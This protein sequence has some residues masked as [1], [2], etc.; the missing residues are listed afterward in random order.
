MKRRSRVGAGVSFLPASVA[1]I[2]SAIVAASASCSSSSTAQG[3]EGQH[4]FRNGTCDVGLLCLSDLC[5]RPPDGGLGGGGRGGNG[6]NGGTGG[7]TGG[8]STAGSTGAGGT[9][10]RGGAGGVAGT[11]AG[12]TGGVISIGGSGGS[13]ATGTCGDGVITSGEVC[14]DGNTAGGDGCAAD[15]RSATAGYVCPVPGRPCFPRCG[16]G[17]KIGGEGCDDGNA[18]S[19]DG[20]SAVCQVEPGASCTGAAGG[21]STCTAS[22][23]G[24]G[25]KEGNEGCDC[26]SDPANLPTGCKGPNGLFFGDASGCSKACTKEPTCR[27]SSGKNQACSVSCGNG[28]VEMGEACDDGNNDAGDG[29]SPTCTVET[30]FA[31]SNVMQDDSVPCADAANGGSTAKCLQQPIIYRDFKNESAS[32]GHPDFFYLGALV[33]N[34][35]TVAGVD[36]QGGSTSFS[37]RYCVPN[38]SGPAKKNDA[39]NRCWDLAQ[40][41]L[42]ST[43]KPVFN[44]ARTGA[45]SNPLFCD[46]QFIDWSTDGSAG[47]LPGYT[48]AA[49]GPTNGLTFTDGGTGHP[50]YR[51]PAPVVTSA[52][53]FG[54]W[55]VDS[56]STGNT[57]T[58]GNLEMKSVASGTYQFS[59]QVNIVTGGFFPLDPPGHGFPLYATAPAGPGT[60]PLVVGTEA[61]LCNLW[62]YWY[63]SSTFGAGNSC[64]GDQYLYPPSLIPPDTTGTCPGGTNCAGKWYVAQ[65]G[66]FHDFWFTEEARTLFTYNG[67]FTLRFQAADDLFVFING[68]L[69]VDLGGIHQRLPGA[70][71]VTGATGMASIQEG[72]SVDATGTNLLPCGTGADP[73]TGVAFNLPTGTDGLNHY[74][75]TSGTC[76][77]RMRTLNLGLQMGRTYEIAVFGANRHPV[78]SDLELTLSGLQNNRSV[79]RP[80][81]GDGVRNGDEQCDCGDASTPSSDPACSGKHNQDDA[82]GGCTTQCKLGPYCG[83]ALVDPAGGEQCDLGAAN[84][85]TGVGGCTV[86][87]RY[88]VTP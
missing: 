84:G 31:C 79:C 2:A 18:T 63:S 80:R 68:I 48:Q 13:A 78:E 73:F 36:G 69:V 15:C 45:G 20:C 62:P 33:S 75:C 71:Y 52:T 17:M 22:L 56:A 26:G 44:M 9:A 8:S 46:C 85:V 28:A 39:T 57:H 35:V 72:G 47:H 6:G 23:C 87:C 7:A 61:M 25:K 55:W 65:Q 14:D 12:G 3:A 64:R 60:T 70:V 66:W 74:N 50:M 86:G 4:C 21:K 59:S 30:G 88:G 67:D 82:Y 27:D 81:C 34:P 53:T 83:D 43:G 32:G 5:V 49:N 42:G 58:V 40:A 54:Q 41:T 16:D 24:N 77:C 76:D 19:G 11:G 37:K 51:G 10:G 29:C 38:S 1:V